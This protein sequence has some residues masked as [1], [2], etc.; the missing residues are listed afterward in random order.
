MT[1]V[2]PHSLHIV[3]SK[4]LGGAEGFFLRLAR[5]LKDG[6]SADEVERA[7]GVHVGDIHSPGMLD[8]Q[9]EGA[10]VGGQEDRGVVR[11]GGK[12]GEFMEI[13]EGLKGGEQLV[14]VGQNNL[15]E[16][17]KVHVAR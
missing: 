13:V 5:A 4:R 6:F 11:I 9:A 3:G 7:S 12:Y 1:K 16:G 10:P 14:V 2:L 15:A 8:A 17:V